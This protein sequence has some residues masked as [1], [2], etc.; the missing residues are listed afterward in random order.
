MS[1]DIASLP[2][3]LTNEQVDSVVATEDRWTPS[4]VRFPTT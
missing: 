4:A 1:H 3:R 2:L